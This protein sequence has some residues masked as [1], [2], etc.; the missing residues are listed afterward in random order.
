MDPAGHPAMAIELTDSKIRPVILIPAASCL[1]WIDDDRL[2]D[3]K[4]INCY[5]SH[6]VIFGN[7]RL[8]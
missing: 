5:Q 4:D 8:N 6:A 1:F 3:G 2:F 7:N